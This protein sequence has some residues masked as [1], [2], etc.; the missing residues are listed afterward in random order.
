MSS[1]VLVVPV[2]KL[3]WTQCQL[4]HYSQDPS[5]LDAGPQPIKILPRIS[6]VFDDFTC[7]HE[8]IRFRQW[9]FARRVERIVNLHRMSILLKHDG[10]SGARSGPKIQTTT[11]GRQ[12]GGYRFEEAG[13]KCS[14]SL[15][16]WT[17]LMQI[18]LSFFCDRIKM[19]FGLDEDQ[20]AI[21]TT[22]IGS[23]L[24]FV[25]K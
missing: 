19:L 22:K 5:Y 18:V 6:E 7:G 13:K 16:Q 8:I 2:G 4:G 3:G 17:V 1:V 12:S 21:A 15:V 23:P 14:I 11:I 20:L 25:E 24:V 10:K 9:F